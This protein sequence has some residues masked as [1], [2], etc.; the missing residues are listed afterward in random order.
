MA[1]ILIELDD[2]P[3]LIAR[4]D[5]HVQSMIVGVCNITVKHFHAKQHH[6]GCSLKHHCWPNSS[7]HCYYTQLLK[8]NKQ[9]QNRPKKIIKIMRAMKRSILSLL[10]DEY[11][12]S[13]GLR[14][15]MVQSIMVIA[16][17]ITVC[18]PVWIIIIF[19]KCSKREKCREMSQGRQAMGQRD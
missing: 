17:K 9:N 13:P 15:A 16:W 19:L 1:E 5:C 12:Y 18:L 3:I 7:K 6:V 4:V 8:E 14:F 11:M 2:E 10:H